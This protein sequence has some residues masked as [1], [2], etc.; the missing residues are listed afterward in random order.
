MEATAKI[1]AKGQI[2]VPKAVRDALGV[3]EGDSLI[4]RVEDGHATVA[5]NVDLLDLA[6]TVSVPVAVRGLP[7]NEIRNRAWRA[8]AQDIIG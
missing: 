2:T 5:A 6:G 8:R 4:F 3:K 1:T 7:W